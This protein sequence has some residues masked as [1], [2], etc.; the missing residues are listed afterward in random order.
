M[1]TRASFKGINACLT[2]SVYINIQ[3]ILL[4]RFV[5]QV[6]P[7]GLANFFSS[8]RYNIGPWE[9]LLQII[10]LVLLHSQISSSVITDTFVQVAFILIHKLS[11]IDKLTSLLSKTGGEVQINI[12][13]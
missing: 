9:L 7:V 1:V 13:D 12:V 5:K 10:H 8:N 4:F 3:D 2:S 6:E 11:Y